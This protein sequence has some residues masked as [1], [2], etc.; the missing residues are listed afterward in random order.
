MKGTKACMGFPATPSYPF[1]LFSLLF[2]FCISQNM[3]WT[4]LVH[5]VFSQQ[6]IFFLPEKGTFC[7]NDFG[8]KSA[9]KP[10]VTF[11][12]RRLATVGFE[13]G[14]AGPEPAALAITL[15]RFIW[16]R[17]KKMHVHWKN[18]NNQCNIFTR[19]VNIITKIQHPNQLW[20][21]LLKKLIVV[22]PKMFLVAASTYGG[23]CFPGCPAIQQNSCDAKCH[24]TLST[25]KLYTLAH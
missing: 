15:L 5:E 10:V 2:W 14:E 13:P 7:T 9:F 4:H 6:G 3:H 20:M 18:L 8:C 22:G 1:G 17:V 16:M 21:Q 19:H 23:I 11:W 24:Q 25:D 12:K